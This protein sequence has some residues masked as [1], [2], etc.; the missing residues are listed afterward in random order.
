MC[1]LI[2]QNIPNGYFT[3]LQPACLARFQWLGFGDRQVPI[4]SFFDLDSSPT[5]FE[6][7]VF[8]IWS[9]FHVCWS[10]RLHSFGFVD[11]QAAWVITHLGH[12]PKSNHSLSSLLP[13][14]CLGTII[15]STTCRS[16]IPSQ[17]L[18]KWP[19]VP[20]PSSSVRKRVSM[21]TIDI[22]CDF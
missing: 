7:V 21:D 11:W 16:Q 15:S 2:K 4:P 14:V 1:F 13:Q 9:A 8:P 3:K 17:L 19:E 18:P 12:L 22:K 20:S 10:A 6:C 5:W